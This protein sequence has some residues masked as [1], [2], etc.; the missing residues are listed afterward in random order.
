M[1]NALVSRCQIGATIKGAKNLDS[2]AEIKTVAGDLEK[3][4]QDAKGLIT[5]YMAYLEREG[6]SEG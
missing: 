2:A 1:P 5:K 3:L 6:Y 4:P